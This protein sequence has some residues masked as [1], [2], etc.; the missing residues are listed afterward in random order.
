[1]LQFGPSLARVTGF[2]VGIAGASVTA[3]QPLVA[4]GGCRDGVP[5]GAYELYGAEGR[6]RGEPTGAGRRRA[7]GQA[8]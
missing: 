6:L 3:A 1:M 2:A 7:I 8:A 5:N 4:T